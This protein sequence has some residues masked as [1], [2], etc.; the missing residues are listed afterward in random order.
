[1]VGVDIPNCFVT[2]LGKPDSISLVV[3]DKPIGKD[4]GYVTGIFCGWGK[5]SG[6]LFI[7]E[8]PVAHARDTV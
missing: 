7:S 3:G 2:K 4:N 1:M 8:F 6:V 5:F